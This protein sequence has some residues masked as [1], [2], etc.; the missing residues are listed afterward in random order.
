MNQEERRWDSKE[1]GK[2]PNHL[3]GQSNLVTKGLVIQEN[4]A[5]ECKQEFGNGVLETM[6]LKGKS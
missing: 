5:M 1:T 4:Q 6:K 2:I 3:I